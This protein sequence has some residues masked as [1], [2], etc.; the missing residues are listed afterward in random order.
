[1]ELINNNL[2]YI[3]LRASHTKTCLSYRSKRP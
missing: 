3:L 1:M 2:S